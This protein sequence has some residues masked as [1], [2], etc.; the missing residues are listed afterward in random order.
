M[1][2]GGRTRVVPRAVT[3]NH[4]TDDK[5]ETHEEVTHFANKPGVL[6]LNAKLFHIH[7]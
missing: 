2:T 6:S 4:F 3:H 7:K 5:T 1:R